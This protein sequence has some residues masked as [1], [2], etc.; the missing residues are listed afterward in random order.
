ME[1]DIRGAAMVGQLTEVSPWEAELILNLR[2]WQDG[3]R[4]QDHVWNSYARVFGPQEGRAQLDVFEQLLW[5][6]EANMIRPLVR[7]GVACRCIG[8]D[9]AVF[10][11]MVRFASDGEL[12]EASL[13]A[14]LMVRPAHAEHVALLAGEVGTATRELARGHNAARDGLKNAPFTMH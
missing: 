6:I 2:L 10:A 5:V 3:V 14:T 11:N 4:G 1:R 9:E 7:H 8:S 13:I 12:H